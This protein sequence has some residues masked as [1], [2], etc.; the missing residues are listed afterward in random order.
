MQPIATDEVVWSVGLSIMTMSPSILAEPIEMLFA[1]WTLVGPRNYV[2]DGLQISP[3]EGAFLRGDIGIFAQTAKHHYQ[4][5]I[6]FESVSCCHLQDVALL[7]IVG[8]HVFV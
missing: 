4:C 5:S 7:T 3:W 1:M 8:E 2:L 6:L